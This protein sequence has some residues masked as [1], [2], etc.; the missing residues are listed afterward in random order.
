MDSATKIQIDQVRQNIQSANAAAEI[1]LAQLSVAA[2]DHDAVAGKRV[3]VVEDGPT[4]THGGMAF[5]AGLVAA[6]R[7]GA[8]QIV[9]PLPYAVGRMARTFADYPHVRQVIPAMGYS[10]EQ[11]EDLEVTINACPC[12][13][14]V[15]ATPIDLPKLVKI[16]KPCLRVRYE[17]QNHDAP[18]LES[19]MQSRLKAV[20]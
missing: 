16:N 20:L 8:S 12:D 6:R 9:D 14:V 3:L 4:L 19:A 10:P 11:I 5:G 18:T 2:A 13:M 1:V 17:Y 15:F 7:W